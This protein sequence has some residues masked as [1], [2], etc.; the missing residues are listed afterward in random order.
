MIR[1]RPAGDLPMTFVPHA[2]VAINLK[3]IQT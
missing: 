2:R 1:S 3:E